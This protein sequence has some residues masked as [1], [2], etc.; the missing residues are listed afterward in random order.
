M[1]P[2]QTLRSQAHASRGSALAAAREEY[3]SRALA[4]GVRP[5]NA[6]MNAMLK[7]YAR[8]GDVAGLRQRLETMREAGPPASA[9]RLALINSPLE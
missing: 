2:W 9:A 4:A 7:V 5:G 3:W 1:T 6:M 8:T